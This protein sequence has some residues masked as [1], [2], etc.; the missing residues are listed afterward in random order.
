MFFDC[1]MPR[2]VAIVSPVKDG[3]KTKPPW[4]PLSARKG[5]IIES[6]SATTLIPPHQLTLQIIRVL[7]QIDCPHPFHEPIIRPD[8]GI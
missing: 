5:E 6:T 2:A 4:T 7:P 1:G 8:N 3:S